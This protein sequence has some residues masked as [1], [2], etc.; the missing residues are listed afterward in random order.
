MAEFSDY[1]IPAGA[2]L[3]SAPLRRKKR[4][5][6]LTALAPMAD[7]PMPQGQM[8]SGIYVKPGPVAALTAGLSRG[9]GMAGAFQQ[10][11]DDRDMEGQLMEQRQQ[12]LQAQQAERAED[13]YIKRWQ[14]EAAMERAS[15]AEDLRR[16]EASLRERELQY[17]TEAEA[18][19]A[20]EF[21][22]RQTYRENYQPPAP[23]RVQPQA[24]PRAAVPNVDDLIQ[25]YYGG[26]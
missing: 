2:P 12:A 6:D 4:R 16:Q 8:V 26:E 15:R 23:R 1:D 9:L 19:R 25:K 14:A 22:R 17:R 20:A 24:R 7:T 11:R 13:R 10:R 21:D 3:P 5:F 18:R